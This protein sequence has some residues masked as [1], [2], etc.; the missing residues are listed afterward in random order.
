MSLTFKGMG[1]WVF[2]QMQTNFGLAVV[3]DLTL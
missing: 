3:F 1:K 2:G